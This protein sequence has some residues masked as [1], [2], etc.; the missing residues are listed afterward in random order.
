MNNS[1]L[2]VDLIKSGVT[3][4]KLTFQRMAAKAAREMDVEGE[5]EL[6]QTIRGVLKQETAFSLQKTNFTQEKLSAS[7]LSLPT[8]NET[9]FHLA[10]KTEPDTNAAPPVL[11][12]SIN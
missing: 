10:D 1:E 6:A 11:N 3:G 7:T 2:I 8:D 5:R 12:S 4:D 9:K